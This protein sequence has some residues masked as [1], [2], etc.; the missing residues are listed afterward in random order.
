MYVLYFFGTMLIMHITDILC[1]CSWCVS[2]YFS[3]SVHVLVQIFLLK[4]LLPSGLLILFKRDKCPQTPSATL[5]KTESQDWRQ[6][7]FPFSR[8][9]PFFGGHVCYFLWQKEF[10]IPYLVTS[11]ERDPLKFERKEINRSYDKEY[12][13]FSIDIGLKTCCSRPALKCSRNK[14][15]LVASII[16]FWNA[17]SKGWS[18]LTLYI[19]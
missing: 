4:N 9:I 13:V 10:L 19:L 2:L 14:T 7:K 16:H 17:L 1:S 12:Q 8:K 5:L 18:F 6:G 3:L 11:R 15:D